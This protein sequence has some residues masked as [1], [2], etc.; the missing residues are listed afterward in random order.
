MGGLQRVLRIT[1]E[2]TIK[3]DGKSVTWVW[4]YANEKPRI[5]SEMTKEEIKASETK[6]YEALKRELPL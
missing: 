2:M 3:A 6:K 4:D 5:K 1:G